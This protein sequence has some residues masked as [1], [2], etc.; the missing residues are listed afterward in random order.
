MPAVPLRQDNLCEIHDS[1]VDVAVHVGLTPC[2]GP[3]GG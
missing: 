1:E 2:D 3:E